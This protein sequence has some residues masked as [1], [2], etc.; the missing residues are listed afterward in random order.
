MKGKS[1]WGM[2]M[3]LVVVIILIIAGWYIIRAIDE[4]G[5]ATASP[6]SSPIAETM[7]LTIYFDNDQNNPNAMNCGAVYP[8]TRTVSR[9]ATV[10]TASLQ[11][12]FKGPTT[13]EQARGYHSLFSERTAG[14]LRNVRVQDGVAYV[15]L[16]DMRQLIPSA[17]A[18]CGG[19]QF[20]AEMNATVTQFPTVEKAIYAINGDPAA[21]Y[22]FIQM[23]CAAE[24]NNC[25]ATPFRQ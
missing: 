14:L 15:D 21:F 10:A 4:R 2:L 11:E 6:S 12:L 9:T 16:Q 25:D 8:V 3:G 24:N 22:E 1:L 20:M 23:G 5:K 17:S 18:S 19:A 13:T 7:S